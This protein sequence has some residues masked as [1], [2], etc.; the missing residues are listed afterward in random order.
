[1][2]YLSEEKKAKYDFGIVPT[3]TYI[4]ADLLLGN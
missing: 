3:G 2:D 1:M 4:V